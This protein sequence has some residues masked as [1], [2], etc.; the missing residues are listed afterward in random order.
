LQPARRIEKSDHDAP[1]LALS[2]AMFRKAM[3]ANKDMDTG[4]SAS[5]KA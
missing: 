2:L 3:V 4:E 1:G 5:D